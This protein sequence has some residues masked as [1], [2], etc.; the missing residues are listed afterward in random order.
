[1]PPRRA[2]KCSINLCQGSLDLTPVSPANGRPRIPPLRGLRQHSRGG[3]LIRDQP[4]LRRTRLWGG[5]HRGNSSQVGP[6][7]PIHYSNPSPRQTRPPRKGLWTK[8]AQTRIPEV[9]ARGLWSVALWESTP[10]R[11]QVR[12]AQ[13]HVDGRPRPEQI[14]R[15]RAAA[16]RGSRRR[17]LVISLARLARVASSSVY[18]QAVRGTGERERLK[19]YNAVSEWEGLLSVYG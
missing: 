11:G 17:T 2:V 15:A 9:H 5:R 3:V 13:R 12:L 19:A 14:D 4:R 18:S 8:Q 10:S 1:M 16:S 6:R 7:K